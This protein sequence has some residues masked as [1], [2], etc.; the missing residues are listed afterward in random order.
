LFCCCVG[1]YWGYL[2][3]LGSPTNKTDEHSIKAA[4]DYWLDRKKFQSPDFIK[5]NMEPNTMLVLGSSEFSTKNINTHPQNL[6]LLQG[7]NFNTMLVGQGYYQSLW[8]AIALGAL[9]DGVQNRK[10][11]IIVSAQWFAKNGVTSAEFSGTYSKPMMYQFMKNPSISDALKEKVAAR[12]KNL[13]STT[14]SVENL[15]AMGVGKSNLFSGIETTADVYLNNIRT[16]KIIKSANQNYKN[17][18]QNKEINSID[19]N[20]LSIKAEQDGAK[21]CTNNEFG[22][23]DTYYKTYME[24]EMINRKGSQ[25]DLSYTISPEYDDFQLFLDVC[26]ETKI[27]PLIIIVPVNG[28]WSDYTEF[29]KIERQAYYQK[30]RNICKQN[31]VNYADF[32]GKEYEKYFLS[33]VM[34]LGWKGWVDIDEAIV[35]FAR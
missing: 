32:S 23:N 1:G 27:K 25:K 10:V 14:T 34:H 4:N 6:F 19:W 12:V 5:Q 21:A 29:S 2:H 18:P 30:I 16:A 15:L 3:Q 28:F 17:Y 33:D 9:D 24:K 22:V 20:Q 31:N 35:K 11:A 7:Y 13:D 8:H 26:K